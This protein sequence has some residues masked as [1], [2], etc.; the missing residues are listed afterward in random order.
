MRHAAGWVASWER[1]TDASP[2]IGTHRADPRRCTD[3]GHLEDTC[4]CPHDCTY[5]GDTDA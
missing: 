1:E 3:C 5:E 4:Q 2:Y